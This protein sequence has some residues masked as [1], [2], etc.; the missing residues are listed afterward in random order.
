VIASLLLAVMLQT[1]PVEIAPEDEIVVI[2]RKLGA[3]SV[4]VGKDARGKFTCQ[5][6]QSTGRASLDADLCKTAAK[7]VRKGAGTHDAVEACVEARKP[8]LLEA[9]R[10]SL[11]KA[12]W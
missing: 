5:L 8:E 10:Q 4:S 3:V 11:G 6:D 9:V 2:A 1:V 12:G 7:C